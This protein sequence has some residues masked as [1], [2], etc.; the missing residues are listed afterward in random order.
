[1]RR[2]PHE[3]IIYSN[4]AVKIELPLMVRAFNF[5]PSATGKF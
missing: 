2:G 3:I 4:Y 1:V 5:N